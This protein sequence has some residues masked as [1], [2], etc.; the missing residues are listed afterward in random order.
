MRV[1]LRMGWEYR[2]NIRGNFTLVFELVLKQIYY[3]QFYNTWSFNKL[4][5]IKTKYIHRYTT[6][7]L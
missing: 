3:E 2:D 5:Y 1:D 4:M 7:V 6:E